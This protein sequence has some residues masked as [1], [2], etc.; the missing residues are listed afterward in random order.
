MRGQGVVRRHARMMPVPSRRR[1]AG[2]PG[3][4]LWVACRHPRCRDYA[5][6][7][8]AYTAVSGHLYLE[9]AGHAACHDAEARN[10]G[11]PPMSQRS[12]L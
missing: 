11:R 2:R 12:S 9:F 5:L 6:E 3:E 1:M 7:V 4:S 10:R 8:A